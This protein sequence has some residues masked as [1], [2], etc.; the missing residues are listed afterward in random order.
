MALAPCV[1]LCS[2][3]A[4]GTVRGDTAPSTDT[5]TETQTRTVTLTES[6]APTCETD[7]QARRSTTTWIRSPAARGGEG[8][9]Y[10][11]SDYSPCDDLSYAPSGSPAPRN[12]SKQSQLMLFHRGEYV[13]VGALAPKAMYVTDRTATR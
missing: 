12:P 4:P 6:P 9:Y 11:Q 5:Q 13:G 2:S 10:G 7:P 1:P 8:G 3:V